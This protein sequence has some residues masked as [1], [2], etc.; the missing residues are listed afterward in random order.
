ME[1]ICHGPWE[2]GK[3][4][5]ETKKNAKEHP[6]RDYFVAFDEREIL[7]GGR[8]GFHKNLGWYDR[9]FLIVVF[10]RRKIFFKKI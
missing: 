8:K 5:R 10:N 4:E 6:W 1:S 7:G 2:E 3:K 9:M